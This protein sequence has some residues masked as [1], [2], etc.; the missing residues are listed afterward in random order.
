VPGVRFQRGAGATVP[1][2]A[3]C[4][5]EI[6]ADACGLTR[7]QLHA[8]LRAENVVTRKYFY[9][10]CSE[11]RCYRD[12]PSAEPDRLPHARR[13]ASRV[14]CLPL[15]GD[16]GADAVDRIVDAL[17]TIREHAPAIRRPPAGAASTVAA[18]TGPLVS[19]VIPV[20]FNEDNI[21]VTWAALESALARLPAGHR[22]EVV[23][24][25][26]GSGDRSYERLVELFDRAP[27]R[28]R[29]V[30]L[31]RNFG[32]VAAILAGLEQARGDC[33]VVMSADL[34][35]PP[36]LILEMVERWGGGARKIVLATRIHREE[37]LLTR[38]AS[39]TFYRLMR[40][41][42]IP[43]MPEGGF[44]FFLIDRRVVD[45]VNSVEEKN[46]FL[47]GHVLWAGFVPEVIGYTRRKR[48]IGRSR[49]TLSKRVKYFIDGFVTYTVAP[50]RLI[51]VVG[52]VV[53]LFSFGYAALI[54]VLRLGWGLPVKGW[55]PIIISVLMLSGVQLLMLGIIG[56]YLWR[57]YHETRKLPNSVVE[58]VLRSDR[59]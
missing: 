48:E 53:S 8:A 10:L 19:V 56:E 59:R 21:P 45:L 39:R 12:L 31:T 26:D 7:D 41:Y 20:Y 37:N 57:S 42:A 32:Q 18:T 13:L 49:W 16:L 47:Q 54:L 22:W 40:R 2:H 14:L 29:V 11:N 35:D 38:Y 58:S 43:N 44:D 50:I 55:A 52:L 36:E 51:T 46:T 17:L 24:V 25:D 34:Q 4:T 33:C 23:F 3:Y 6:D 9:P 1:N 15:Y 30:K 28:V 5:V 27:D